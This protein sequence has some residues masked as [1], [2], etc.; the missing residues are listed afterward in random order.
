MWFI[1]QR[2]QPLGRAAL[3]FI[4][5][6][7]LVVSLTSRTCM[8]CLGLVGWPP[9]PSIVLQ[10]KGFQSEMQCMHCIR[11]VWIL[12]IVHTSFI[13]HCTLRTV[14][15]LIEYSYTV[16]QFS[17][18]VKDDSTPPIIW[19]I[20]KVPF[21]IVSALTVDASSGLLLRTCPAHSH[22]C[23][24]WLWLARSLLIRFMLGGALQRIVSP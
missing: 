7:M 18:I 10:F 23:F 9:S 19:H 3:L 6:K 22:R 5:V 17:Y 24:G 12:N 11:V 21:C 16:I 13:S 15:N 2:L 8:Y 14:N 20:Q 1:E 4:P